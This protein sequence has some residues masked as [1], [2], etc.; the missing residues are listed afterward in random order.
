MQFV[1]DAGLL[2]PRL[3]L[4]THSR[5]QSLLFFSPIDEAEPLDIGSQAQPRNQ[6]N[7]LLGDNNCLT[8]G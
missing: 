3:C 4:G 6:L 7:R 2:V 5:R 1:L 8:V